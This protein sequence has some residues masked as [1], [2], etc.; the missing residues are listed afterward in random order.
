MRLFPSLSDSSP[1]K[2]HGEKL[3]TGMGDGVQ[4]L[5]GFFSI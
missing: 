1:V 5:F 3:S 4:F 2:T